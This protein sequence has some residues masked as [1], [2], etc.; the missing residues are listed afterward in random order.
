[1]FKTPASVQMGGQ[2]NDDGKSQG[3]ALETN[4]MGG[5][6]RWPKMS[7]GPH[8]AQGRPN[9][10][11]PDDAA[12]SVFNLMRAHLSKKN[13]SILEDAKLEE[14]KKQKEK[15]S[16]KHSN[17]QVVTVDMPLKL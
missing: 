8:N 7:Q 4:S 2:G 16:E 10:E 5:D 12:D 6:G 14:A 3:A 1:M 11:P 15:H 9:P 17:D 13:K